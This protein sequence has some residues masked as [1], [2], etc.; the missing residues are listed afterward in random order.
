METLFSFNLIIYTQCHVSG[1]LVVLPVCLNLVSYF[2]GEWVFVVFLNFFFTFV[3]LS[4]LLYIFP[5]P[6]SSMDLL[7]PWRRNTSSS[8]FESS[9]R[10]TQQSLSP[11]STHRSETHPAHLTNK[12]SSTAVIFI[13]SLSLSYHSSLSIWPVLIAFDVKC[14]RT[15]SSRSFCS[16]P[17]LPLGSRIEPSIGR[18]THLSIW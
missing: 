7:C 13:N 15:W 1:F 5:S 12:K 16:V 4:C 10:C 9:S 6:A 11:F 8:W 2:W 14:K 17:H 3:F 18:F